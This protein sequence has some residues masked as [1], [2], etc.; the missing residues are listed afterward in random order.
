MSDK[1]FQF[2]I[3]G[4]GHAGK[5][6]AAAIRN[7]PYAHL[8]AVVEPN[9]NATNELSGV[10]IFSN[11]QDYLLANLSAHIAIVATPNGLHT[12]M[13]SLALKADLHVVVEKPMGI[14]VKTCQELISLAK[15]LN[16]QVFVVKQNR[17]SPPAMWM[18]EVIN[19]GLL[20]N[21]QQVQINCLWNR[22][23]RYYTPGSWR[24]TKALDGGPL[25]TQFSHFIDILYWVFGDINNIQA[26]FEKFNHHVNTQMEDS[27]WVWFDLKQGGKGSLEYTTAVWDSNLES[28]M[29]VIGEHGSFKIGGQY[30]NEVVHCNIKNYTMPTLPVTNAPNDYGPF[31]GSA[32]NHQY[33]IENVINVLNGNTLPTTTPEEAM[34]VVDMIE[35]IYALRK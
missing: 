7:N 8:L 30:M 26:R 11:W 2:V 27:G 13:A 18:K 22:D 14:S 28:S 12:E 16:K 10:A 15:S 23:E 4:Y 9:P 6:H 31:K 20:G 32:A 34:H 1:P 21:I 5:K 29:T 3:I 25:F 17:Y 24:G 33:V 35:R 19:K